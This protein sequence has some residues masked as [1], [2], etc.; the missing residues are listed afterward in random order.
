MCF[1]V[2]HISLQTL[3]PKIRIELITN[4]YHRFVLPI[5]LSRNISQERAFT[6]TMDYA[7]SKFHLILP[8]YPQAERSVYFPPLDYFEGTTGIEP[9]MS[10][11]QGVVLPL[12]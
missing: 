3:D 8:K 4:P 10:P 2:T 12:N 9:I 7:R 1:E 11:S 6:S 5:K